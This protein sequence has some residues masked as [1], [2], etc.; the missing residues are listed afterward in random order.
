[1]EP[2]NTLEV[3]AVE[4]YRENLKSV[5]DHYLRP[6]VGDPDRNLRIISV[7]CG[8]GYEAEPLLKTFP[9]ATY[10]G[11][12]IK[13]DRIDAAREFNADLGGKCVFETADAGEKGAFN[14][15]PWDMVV[16]RHP[17]V[18]GSIGSIR[19]PNLQE[20]WVSIMENCISALNKGGVLFISTDTGVE[21]EQ[22]L[23]WINTHSNEIKIVTDERNIHP[24]SKG[25]HKDSFVIVGKKM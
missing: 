21:R 3:P 16:V 13:A 25:I 14:K 23:E 17:Q 18:L 8:F 6:L 4:H 24:S 1:M 19:D 2:I 20:D 22:I 10:T 7:G 12:D 15:G 11:I 5:F 9:N